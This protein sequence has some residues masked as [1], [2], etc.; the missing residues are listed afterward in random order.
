[1]TMFVIAEIIVD[2]DF[3]ARGV[4]YGSD[5]DCWWAVIDPR[6]HPLYVWKKSGC[7]IAGYSRSAEALDACI[8]TNGPM[9]GK[10][11]GNHR[12]TRRVSVLLVFAKWATVGLFIGLVGGY[13]SAILGA[14]VG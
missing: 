7:S 5:R 14:I 12:L 1:M 11:L 13:F 10:H 6:V 2:P 8:F 4:V 3:R 9:M